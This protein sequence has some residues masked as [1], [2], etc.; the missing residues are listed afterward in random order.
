MVSIIPNFLVLYFGENFMK[1]DKKYQKY[2][3]IQKLHVFIHIFM[4]HF[5]SFYGG[6]LKQLYIAN[7][8]HGF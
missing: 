4:P 3:C 7:F 2:R 1:Y 5:M 6:Q 8:L